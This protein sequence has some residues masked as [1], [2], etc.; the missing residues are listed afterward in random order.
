MSLFTSRAKRVALFSV[1]FAIVSCGSAPS[2]KEYILIPPETGGRLLADEPSDDLPLQ[3]CGPL[4]CYV[5][6][7][8]DVEKIKKYIVTLEER[9]KACETK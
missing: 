9:L 1:L 8:N 6:F 4:E 7:E 5:Y 3:K 2:V